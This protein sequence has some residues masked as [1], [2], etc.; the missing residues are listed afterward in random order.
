MEVLALT[1]TTTNFPN[2]FLP[3]FVARTDIYHQ[4]PLFQHPPQVLVVMV[5]EEEGVV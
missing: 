4:P 2:C 1:S 3:S 5:M